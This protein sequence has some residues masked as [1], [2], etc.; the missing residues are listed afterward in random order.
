MIYAGGLVQIQKLGKKLFKTYRMEISP[1]TP[2]FFLKHYVITI[3][4][5][6]EV[7]RMW[8]T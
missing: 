4:K 3:K 7:E 6:V 2:L 8:A 5:V 1:K